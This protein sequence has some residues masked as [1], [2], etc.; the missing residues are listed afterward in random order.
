MP[1]ILLPPTGGI[2]GGGGHVIYLYSRPKQTRR[3]PMSN[4]LQAILLFASCAAKQN[5]TSKIVC[6]ECGER[7]RLTKWGFYTRYLFHGDDS[8]EIQRF[9]CL[10]RQ[11]P[12][13]TF[14]ILPHPLLPVVRVPLCF[15]LLLLLMHQKGC[16]VGGT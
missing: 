14:S 1:F 11:C 12:R 15:M 2:R 4:P 5:L 8:L 3:Y 10:N 7:H 9:R 13:F 6:P 16:S